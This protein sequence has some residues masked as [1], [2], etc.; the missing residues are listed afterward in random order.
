M[1]NY[2]EELKNLEN[3]NSN[4]VEKIRES[5]QK[6][7][8]NISSV[9]EISTTGSSSDPL[10]PEE[11]TEI[12]V[13]ILCDSDIEQ[14]EVHKAFKTYIHDGQS[15]IKEAKFSKHRWDSNDECTGTPDCF[16]C[17]REPETEKMTFRHQDSDSGLKSVTHFNKSGIPGFFRF[18][19]GDT[20][21]RKFNERKC[22][23]G[24]QL[25]L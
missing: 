19:I 9:S 12:R 15:D 5:H 24:E 10:K 14:R 7:V 6:H 13:V 23:C 17:I 21:Y 18:A 16:F 4:M 20:S 11:N 2:E 22:M 1:S 8:R 25:R 3:L